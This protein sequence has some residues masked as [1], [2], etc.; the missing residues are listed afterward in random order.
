MGITALLVEKLIDKYLKNE[1]LLEKKEDLMSKIDLFLLMD[2][3]TG[4]EYK[5]LKS[6]IE[7]GE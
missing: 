7:S 4:D 3:I 6:E 1:I 5:Q 2:R